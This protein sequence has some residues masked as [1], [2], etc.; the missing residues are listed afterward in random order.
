MSTPIPSTSGFGTTVLNIG[1][2]ENHGFDLDIRTV[3]TKGVVK[4]NSA[5]NFSVNRNK[6]TNLN[7]KND[8]PMLGGTILRPGEAVGTFYG[9]VFDGI[10]QTDAEAAS[11]PVLIGQEPN[12]P[13]L[14]SRAKAGDR[15]YRDINGD[16]KITE[17]DRTI[18]GTA[19]PDFTWGFS[20]TLSYKNIDLNFFLPGFAGQ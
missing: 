10:F 8:I 17:A 2:I 6:I 13:N 4:W 12:S 14:A 20:N 7:A 9:Y 1:N 19:Q 11:S 18:L 15:K 16:K 3:N 5:I